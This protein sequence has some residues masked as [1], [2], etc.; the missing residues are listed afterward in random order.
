MFKVLLAISLIVSIT[1]VAQQ[2][3]VYDDMEYYLAIDFVNNYDAAKNRCSTI[4]AQLAAI[5]NEGI[6]QFLQDL[7]TNQ[8]A[9]SGDF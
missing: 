6:L 9:L 4:D 5:Y 2:W 7:A 1:A 3:L 8:L